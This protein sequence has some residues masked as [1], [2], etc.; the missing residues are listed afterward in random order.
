[1]A[2]TTAL[3][4]FEVVVLLA[5]LHVGEDA[6]GSAIRDDIEVRSGRPASRGAVYITLDRLEQKG[7]LT[8]TLGEGTTARGM[9]PRRYYRVT[10]D[11]VRTL[12]SSLR[13]VSR[14]HSGLEAVLGKL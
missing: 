8:S 11:G 7:L 10:A 1:M 3:G 13:L 4:E 14:M 12:K 5:V 6:F 9:R 2:P